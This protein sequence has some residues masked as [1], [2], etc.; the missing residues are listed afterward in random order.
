VVLEAVVV[1]ITSSEDGER[2]VGDHEM[3]RDVGRIRRRDCDL[4]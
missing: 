2:M 1:Y 4:R 3:K